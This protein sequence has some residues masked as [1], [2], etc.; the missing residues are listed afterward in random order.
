VIRNA[1]KG[2]GIG[3]K[4]MISGMKMS[5]IFNIKSYLRGVLR[6]AFR[7]APLKSQAYRQAKVGSR[8]RADLYKCEI[9]EKV[10]QRSEA[11][12][13]HKTPVT[14][15]KGWDSWDGFIAR[16]F[17]DVSDLQVICKPCHKTKTLEENETRRSHGVGPGGKES[18]ENRKK[19]MR[20]NISSG[21]KKILAKNLKTGKEIK[22]VTPG[23]ASRML[24]LDRENIKKCL[25][26]ERHQVGDWCFKLLEEK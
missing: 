8:G 17:C 18:I 2:P 9:C 16:L 10:L 19:T 1:V 23:A 4:S 5:K 25:K 11:Q 15:L 14:P 3:I 13:D 21:E 24:N 22:F 6:K 20:K 7:D 12:V 26:N